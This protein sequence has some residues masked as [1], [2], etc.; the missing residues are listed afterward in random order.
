VFVVM[1][2]YVKPMDEVEKHLSA[3]RKWLDEN[4]SAGRFVVSGPRIPRTGGV[5]VARTQ[6]RASLDAELARDPFWTEGI[7]RYDVIEFMPNRM[8]PRLFGHLG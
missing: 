7:A 6:S 1:L 5:I 3:H 4:Y 8:A 2:E